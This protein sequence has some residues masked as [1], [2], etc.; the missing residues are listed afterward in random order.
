MNKISFAA[1]ALASAACAFTQ[2]LP[3]GDDGGV[4][5][6]RSQ[7]ALAGLFDKVWIDVDGVISSQMGQRAAGSSRPR[8]E[9]W[10]VVNG[11]VSPHPLGPGSLASRGGDAGTQ[12]PHVILRRGPVALFLP[13]RCDGD[14]AALLRIFGRPALPGMERDGV[15]PE[16]RAAMARVRGFGDAVRGLRVGACA[17]ARPGEVLMQVWNT[18]SQAQQID[19]VARLELAAGPRV[20]SDTDG[21]YNGGP[22]GPP[23]FTGFWIPIRS[24]PPLNGTEPSSFVIDLQPGC[25][26]QQRI[27]VGL[28]AVG[29]GLQLVAESA[30]VGSV[31]RDFYVRASLQLQASRAGGGGAAVDAERPGREIESEPQLVRLREAVGGA[32]RAQR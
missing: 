23:V 32:R 25:V 11:G 29:R 12:G 18:G 22:A 20:P 27:P 26:Y 7:E 4:R 28:L 24:Q 31:A 5:S 13:T 15:S 6:A 9:A 8:G 17:S 2:T 16:F 10:E 30:G 1:V 21:P 3:P 19:C 14:V